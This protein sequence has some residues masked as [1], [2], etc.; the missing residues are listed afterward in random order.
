MGIWTGLEH[1]R[2]VVVDAFRQNGTTNLATTD[3]FNK[4]PTQ[5]VTFVNENG[6]PINFGTGGSTSVVATLTD[7]DVVLVVGQSN[8][9]TSGAP[10]DLLQDIPDPRMLQYPNGGTYADKLVLARE[11]V[12]QGQGVVEAGNENNISFVTHFGK[13]Y[14]RVYPNRKLAIIPMA[15]GNTGFSTNRW[16]PG[17]DL[18]NNAISQ[19]NKFLTNFPGSKLVA[20]LCSMGERD[21]D[22]GVP[23]NTQKASLLAMLDGLRSSITGATNVPFVICGHSPDW[24]PGDL[25]KELYN[26]MYAK[27]NRSRNYVGYASSLGL[28][29][30]GVGNEIHFNAASMRILGDRYFA[31]W[32]I[33]KDYVISLPPAANTLSAVVVS[34]SALKISWVAPIGGVYESYRIQ[35]RTVGSISWLETPDLTSTTSLLTKLTAN[36]S[37]EVRVAT[38]NSQGR[39]YSSLISATTSAVV[40]SYINPNLWLKFETTNVGQ[41]DYAYG[42]ANPTNMSNANRFVDTV[43]GNVCRFPADGF[44]IV[45]QNISTNYTRAAWIKL[46]SYRSF[47]GI[48]GSENGDAAGRNDVIVNGVSGVQAWNNYG[49]IGTSPEN[50]STDIWIHVAVTYSSVGTTHT[51]YVNGLKQAQFNSTA[52]NPNGTNNQLFI[53]ALTFGSGYWNNPMDDVMVFDYAMT[54]AELAKVYEDTIK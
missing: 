43:R 17:N 54:E 15:I 16:N 11:P 21:H 22:N 9:S 35:Y 41:S 25:L 12:F 51:I 7:Y 46:E 3:Y 48:F 40:T 36:T 44:L 29:G 38:I 39:T 27:L 28:V 2:M 18:Y 33:A 26:D 53:G 1:I 10:I 8:A 37:Y 50:L 31:A 52:H 32:Q 6:T 34:G 23:V 19:T 24:V 14:L 20:V 47:A 5:L 13:N 42:W 49:Y 45:Y 4:L 30:G